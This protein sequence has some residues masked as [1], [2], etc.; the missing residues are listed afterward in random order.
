MKL[1]KVLIV[2]CRMALGCLFII[3]GL[4]K[5]V[6]P[7]GSA[8]K[9]GEYFS[10]FGM[11]W[12]SGCEYFFAIALSTAETLMG[13]MLLFGLLVRVAATGAALFMLF[14]TLLT[15][16]IA[17]AN[18]VTDCGCFGDLLKLTNWQT[19]YKNAFLLLPLSLV[20]LYDAWVSIPRRVK[21]GEVI[22]SAVAAAAVVAMSVYSMRHLPVVDLLPFRVGVNVLEAMQE[23][24]SAQDETRLLYRNLASGEV[25][26]F[27]VTDTTWYDST[28]WEYVDTVVA[29]RESTAGSSVT[30]LAL[31]RDGQDVTAELL[32][33]PGVLLM[34]CIADP[35][36]LDEECANRLADAA[37]EGIKRGYRV[38]AISPVAAQGQSFTADGLEVEYLTVDDVVVKT[39]LRA[40]N[41]LVVLRDG[42]IAAKYSCRDVPETEEM[43]DYMK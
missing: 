6:D 4:A 39:M 41:G 13:F 38:V 3:S 43:P 18:P 37:R 25:T 17:I 15:L 35:A 36:A 28:T 31:L 29:E 23:G 9:F 8:I 1:R 7:M 10:A 27:A 19:F 2:L 12:L 33:Q 32:G 21:V 14:F 40:A 24:A 30:D 26:E 11:D 34:L 16:Y 42:V 22:W 5:G 20:I